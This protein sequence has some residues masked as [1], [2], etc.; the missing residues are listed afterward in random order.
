MKIHLAALELFHT[1]MH[2]NRRGEEHGRI[3]W[4]VVLAELTHHRAGLANVF[5]GAC[6]NCLKNG[7]LEVQNMV[8]EPFIIIIYYLIIINAYYNI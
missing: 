7:N 2:T 6:P 1:E 5:E 4:T 8:Q 3:S